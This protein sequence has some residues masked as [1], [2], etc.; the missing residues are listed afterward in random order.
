MAMNADDRRL[1]AEILQ[2]NED[3]FAELRSRYEERLFTA[4]VWRVES[5]EVAREVVQATFAK[6]RQSLNDFKGDTTLYLWLYRMAALLATER[7]FPAVK[8]SPAISDPHLNA[9][10]GR[11][12]TDAFGLLLQ[13]YE[14]RLFNTVCRLVGNQEEAKDIVQATFIDAYLKRN[15]FQGRSQFF[16]W[17]YRIAM[18]SAIAYKRRQQGLPP[19]A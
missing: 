14:E 19:S 2:G 5:D 18:N 10:A 12:E 6:A 8:P 17:L 13:R 16:T 7:D 9:A 11:G 4:V 15:E 1:I 3:A